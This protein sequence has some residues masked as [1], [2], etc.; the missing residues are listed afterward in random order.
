MYVSDLQAGFYNELL[1]ERVLM[2]V[3]T[4]VDALA[5]CRI[6]Q[7]LFH[8][9]NIRY[10]LVPIARKSDVATAYREHG[11]GISY[12][13]LI[14]CGATWDI[15]E[16][17]KPSSENTVFFIVD[18]HRPIDVYNV[19]NPSQI[20]LLM[21]PSEQ[22]SVPTFDELFRED[23]IEDS[24]SEDLSIEEIADKRRERRLWEERR[25]QLIFDYT[26]FSYYGPSSAVTMFDLCWKMSRGTND[27]LWCAVIGLSDQY[28]NGK[29]EHDKYVLDAGNLQAHITRYSL[30]DANG[31]AES[32]TSTAPMNT[33]NIS[34][35]CELQL[36]LYRHWSLLESLQYTP[37]TACKFKLWSLKGQKKLQE[38]LA[39]IGLPLSQCRQRYA[40]MDVNLRTNIKEWMS[41]LTEKY[42]LDRLTFGCFVASCGYRHRFFAT[43]VAHSL[44]A[45]LETAS[46]QTSE[47]FF[48]ALDALS[49][50]KLDILKGG[51]EEAKTQAVAVFRQVRTFLDMHHVISAGPFLY[52]V[53]Q[54]GVPDSWRFGHPTH[55]IQLARFLLQAHVAASKNR[56]VVNL[57]LVLTAQAS[58][59]TNFSIVVGIPPI[60]EESPKNFF[61]RAFEQASSS[62]HCTFHADFLDASVAT[63]HT[64]DRSKFFDALLRL[65]C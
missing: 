27:V 33:V 9:D 20:R 44:S 60:S 61:G 5:A 23:E 29:I 62:G 51:I 55:L 38:F 11:E 26:Q 56:R 4:D 24:D 50:S 6:L 31:G 25:N 58:N 52:G 13:L 59:D 46:D 16:D 47:N 30:S 14:N 3:A 49:W 34:F 36:L 22:E 32:S 39:E 37:Y 1:H 64:E 28:I 40:C 57:P 12:V 15:L 45:L 43:D 2:L 65:L 48:H 53:V 10:T 35:D 54:D 41:E 42:G 18:S 63:I 17:C 19:Y 7:Y 8:A 21:Q